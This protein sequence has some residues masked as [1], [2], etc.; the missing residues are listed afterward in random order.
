MKLALGL[1][2]F[3]FWKSQEP[4]HKNQR[5]HKYQQSNLHV[6]GFEFMIWVFIGSCFLAIW[7]FPVG[8]FLIPFTL[9]NRSTDQQI[10]AELPFSE[11]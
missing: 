4:K 5:N 3:H 10:F 6:Y 7:L 2:S 11:E 8:Q 1:L 9:P